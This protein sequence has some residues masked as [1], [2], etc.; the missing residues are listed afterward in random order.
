MNIDHLLNIDCTITHVS[1]TGSAD[2]YG[3]P[4]EATTTSTTQCWISRRIPDSS[5]Q[6]GEQSWQLEHLDLFLPADTTIDGG[7]RVT[8]R[9]VT[10][11]VIGP[12]WDHPHPDTGESAYTAAR[13]ARAA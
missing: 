2:V 11:D 1:D 6:T 8:V 10:Y 9:S 13:I 7:D 4:T 12:P 3:N 5:E